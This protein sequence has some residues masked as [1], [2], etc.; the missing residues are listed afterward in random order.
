MRR[1]P[2]RGNKSHKQRDPPGQKMG[3][4]SGKK[5][6]VTE[7][8]LWTLPKG[9]RVR[10]PPPPLQPRGAEVLWT[11][12]R[13]GLGPGIQVGVLT[14][15]ILAEMGEGCQAWRK[16]GL[17]WGGAETSWRAQ[18]SSQTGGP[19]AMTTASSLDQVEATVWRPPPHPQGLWGAQGAGSPSPLG[20]VVFPW[21]SSLAWSLAAPS[22]PKGNRGTGQA[23]SKWP[24]AGSGPSSPHWGAWSH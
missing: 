4:K 1:A 15:G 19:G 3:G 6:Q 12:E 18:D 8:D 11:E 13:R 16:R 20:E 5:H 2:S 14:V 24:G 10:W 21:E 17:P 22:S 7:K 9:T 23:Q